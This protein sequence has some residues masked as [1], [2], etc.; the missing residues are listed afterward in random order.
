MT[1]EELKEIIKAYEDDRLVVLP[2][3]RADTIFF[4]DLIKNKVEAFFVKSFEIGISKHVIVQRG[5]RAD[6]QQ[7]GKTIFLTYAEAEAA[8]ERGSL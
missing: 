2:C 7:F 4:A 8:L 5:L 1:D 6:F 3:N